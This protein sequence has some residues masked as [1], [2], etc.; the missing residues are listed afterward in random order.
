MTQYNTVNVKFSNS[1]LNELKSTIKNGT[2]VIV[3]LSSNIIGDSNDETNF[4]QKLFNFPQNLL[5]TNR[6]ISK[7]GKAFVNNSSANMML[8]KTHLQSGVFLGRLF[9][10]LF[11]TGFPLMK[12][13]LRALAK[14]VLMPLGSTAA[15]SI[16]HAAIKKNI[17]GS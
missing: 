5:L 3:K 16:T 12:S 1:Q 15:A 8:S 14:S 6:Q 10:P 11:K 7:L 4:P 2:E 17:Q 13:V 9:G